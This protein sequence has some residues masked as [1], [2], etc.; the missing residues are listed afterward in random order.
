MT[1]ELRSEWQGG[2][3]SVRS[4]G[5]TFQVEGKAWANALRSEWYILQPPLPFSPFLSLVNSRINVSFLVN[6]G[7]NS[8]IN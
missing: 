4:D 3:N 5:K 8:R 1:V 6:S 2:V 7:I